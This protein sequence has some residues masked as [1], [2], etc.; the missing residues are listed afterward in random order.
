MKKAYKHSILYFLLFSLLLLSSGLMLFEH[1]IGLNV[2]SVLDY[3]LGNQD[4]YTAAKSMDGVLKIVLPHIFAFGLFSMVI[5][6]FLL[7][8]SS[9][10]KAEIKIIVYLTFTSALLEI[11]APF[12]IILGAGFFAYLKIG[13]FVLF[14]SLIIY[15][16]WLLFKSIIHD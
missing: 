6:H 7:F 13:S 1:K 4:K 8:T 2:N 10:N 12:F 9:R 11:A 15:I 3:Y 16:S 14:E 5:L